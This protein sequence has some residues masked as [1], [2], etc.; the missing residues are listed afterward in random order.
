MLFKIFN[1]FWSSFSLRTNLII[2]LICLFL[3]LF[4][5]MTANQQPAFALKH[6]PINYRRMQVCLL[7]RAF[8]QSRRFKKEKKKMHWQLIVRCIWCIEWRFSWAPQEPQQS[9]CWEKLLILQQLQ[10]L[11]CSWSTAKLSNDVLDV[12]QT[13]AP[14]QNNTKNK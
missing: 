8:A 14:I 11:D 9:P 3:F 13:A 7:L 10:L 12:P 1:N 4:F 6:D 5:N 2:L